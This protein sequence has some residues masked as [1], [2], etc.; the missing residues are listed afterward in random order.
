MGAPS[1]PPRPPAG[2]SRRDWIPCRRLGILLPVSEHRDCPY[3]FG[4]EPDIRTGDH[5]LF[6]D[7]RPGEDPPRF[8]FPEGYGRYR[9]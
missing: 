9:R 5:A 1:K 7:F 6:C 3:C 2:G 8:G 4:I